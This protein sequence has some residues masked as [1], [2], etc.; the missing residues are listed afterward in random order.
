MLS[1]IAFNNTYNFIYGLILILIA[2]GISL[3]AYNMYKEANQKRFIFFAVMFLISGFFEFLHILM[4]FNNDY[5][6]FF[7]SF[8]NRLYQ[9]LGLI[10]IIFIQKNSP[11]EKIKAK[12]YTLYTGSI[13]ALLSIE[14]IIIYFNLTPKLY[15]NLLIN[16][17]NS[18]L[19]TSLLSAFVLIELLNKRSPF[20]NF[21]LGLFFLACSSIYV[22]SP[23]FYFSEYRHLMHLVRIL[24]IFLLFLGLDAIKENFQEYR[25][26]L[27]LILLPDLYIILFFII[28][29]TLGNLLFNLNFS[30]KIY[31]SFILFYILSLTI[32]SIFISRVTS[33][34]TKTTQSLSKFDPNKK[35]TLININ[36][37]DEIGILGEN[38][39]KVLETQWQYTQEIKEKQNKIQEL[40]N[41][42]DSFI[43]ALSHD[44]KSPI[45]A[46]QKLIES[47][48][49]DK[50]N[51]KIDEFIEYLEDMY[52][53]NDEILRIVN[54]L[55][56][57]YHLDSD[58]LE[59]NCEETDINFLIE[60]ATHTLKHLAKDENILLVT[61]L[62]PNIRLNCVDKDML[63]RVITNLI[64]NAIKHSKHSGEIK[65]SSRIIEQNIQVSVKDLGRGIPEEE[66]G[67]IFQ[68]YPSSKRTVGTGLGLYISKQIIDAHNGKIW[69]ES[70]AGKGTTFFFTLP[71]NM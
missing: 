37:T 46:E 65:I 15:P 43:A 39:N 14:Y 11:D 53:I 64:S 36:S 13:I 35:P 44:L 59:L 38:I 18:F 29:I 19:F 30:N 17:I 58:K 45:F 12:E 24:G 32:Q 8:L 2:F 62:T 25:L 42:R 22:I 63:S 27:K 10:G 61:D 55:L 28:F 52:K 7:N 49:L 6:Q 21:N 4:I 26:R 5:I 54:N 71:N 67:N 66:K 70:E 56:T 16:S 23:D 33:P 60:S 68:K 34:I 48:L 20:N 47:I 69:F 41:T 40:M 57:A 31:V 50:E 9:C 51:V 1:H 3:K